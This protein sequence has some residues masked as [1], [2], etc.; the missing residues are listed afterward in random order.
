LRGPYIEVTLAILPR[1]MLHL[2]L[3]ATLIYI[4]G[5]AQSTEPVLT[6]TALPNPAG[7]VSVKLDFV[8]PLGA[9]TGLSTLA[10]PESRM[11]IGLGADGAR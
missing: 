10:I 3:A 11:E 6:R 1:S 4:R 8:N 2:S 5:A 7:N 9:S